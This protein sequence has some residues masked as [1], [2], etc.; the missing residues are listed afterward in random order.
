VQTVL[1]LAPSTLTTVLRA[2]RSAASAGS[3]ITLC[4]WLRTQ[5]RPILHAGPRSPISLTAKCW[6]AA[7]E[8]GPPAMPSSLAG[9]ALVVLADRSEL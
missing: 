3:R 8:G 6:A 7:E 9:P 4:R 1:R 2:G 5:H